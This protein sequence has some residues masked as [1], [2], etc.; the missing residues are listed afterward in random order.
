MLNSTRLCSMTRSHIR[1]RCLTPDGFSMLAILALLLASCS[2]DPTRP[3]VRSAASL[4]GS[5]DVREDFSSYT[6]TAQFLGSTHGIYSGVE[7]YGSEY[8]VIDDAVGYEGSGQSLRYDYPNGNVEG[9]DYSVSREVLFNPVQ[10]RN[11][12]WVRV[13][14]R[15]SD[16]YTISSE[17]G[18]GDAWKF[19]HARYGSG[20]WGV[21]W[22]FGD[23]M[24]YA[25]EDWDGS[26]FYLDDGN[27]RYKNAD[28]VDGEW[29]EVWWHIRSDGE[30][31]TGFNEVWIDGV[32][33]G[34]STFTSGTDAFRGLSLSRNH[35]QLPTDREMQMWWGLVEVYYSDP[36]W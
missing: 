15:F 27:G 28:L 35:N 17:F 3:G 8:M 18:G 21:E 9:G 1:K 14:V 30:G 13:A 36:G 23:I 20:R 26:F 19:L 25:T 16:D 11:E 2:S 33:M 4:S 34:S 10:T 29:H 32:H 22:Q 7:I 31:G 12:V 5:P 24:M 6:S